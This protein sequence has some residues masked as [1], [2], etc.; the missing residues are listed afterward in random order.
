MTE[1]DNGTTVPAPSQGK[2]SLITMFVIIEKS[3][4]F[5]SKA[6]SRRK[7]TQNE[8][9]PNPILDQRPIKRAK[10]MDSTNDQEPAHKEDATQV[11]DHLLIICAC[12][13]YNMY[14]TQPSTNMCLR[15]NHLITWHGIVLIILIQA[16][17]GT[18]YQSILTMIVMMMMMMEE[19]ESPVNRY[20]QV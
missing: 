6:R 10:L 20:T 16:M 1:D 19:M 13:V 17:V 11:Y 7:H 4:V 18:H 3:H 9:T 12:H 5:D 15:I 14:R 8:T 2:V